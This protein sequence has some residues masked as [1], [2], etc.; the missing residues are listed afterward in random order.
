MTTK[1]IIF[2]F[3]NFLKGFFVKKDCCRW[4]VRY[5]VGGIRWSLECGV[6]SL[7]LESGSQGTGCR[8]CRLQDTGRRVQVT[9]TC[10]PCTHILYPATR[11][12]ETCDLRPLATC[13]LRLVSPLCVASSPR[14]ILL[15]PPATFHF[16]INLTFVR[17]DTR[18]LK[19][20]EI[21]FSR[22]GEVSLTSLTGAKR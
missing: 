20:Y 15:S 19:R 18:A 1:R 22:I 10:L 7:E 3:F 8:G 5:Q 13:D 17:Y 12:H 4:G 2:S 6:F 11:Q 16:Q 21:P 9:D 14:I